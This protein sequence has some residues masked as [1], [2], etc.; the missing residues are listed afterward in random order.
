M[1]P[2]KTQKQLEKEKT[3]GKKKYRVEKEKMN[4]ADYE[5]KEFKKKE[6]VG[7]A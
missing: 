6:K 1:K 7:A 5:I 3:K 2:I 4:E